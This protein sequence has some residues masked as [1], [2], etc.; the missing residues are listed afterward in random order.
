MK[1][2]EEEAKEFCERTDKEIGEMWSN[3]YHELPIQIANFVKE[4]KCVE[5]EKIK[6]QIDVLKQCTN[7]P[8]FDWEFSRIGK[9]IIQLEKQLKELEDE[10]NLL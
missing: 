9:K 1:T 3:D 5:A 8:Q 7:V 6:A 4:S 10:S 2:L